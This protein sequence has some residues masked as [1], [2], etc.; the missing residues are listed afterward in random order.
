M[1][2]RLCIYYTLICA[3]LFGSHITMS[4]NHVQLLL[5]RFTD[6]RIDATEKSQCP[7]VCR[8]AVAYIQSNDIL[9]MQSATEVAERF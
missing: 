2:I 1:Y 8:I 3:I 9:L 4:I 7:T 5:A 6:R